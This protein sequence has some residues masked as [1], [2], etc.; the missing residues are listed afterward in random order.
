MK[1]GGRKEGG[2]EGSEGGKKEEKEGGTEG[3][4]EEERERGREGGRKRGMEG[5]MVRKRRSGAAW[6]QPADDG[7]GSAQSV[8]LTALPGTGWLT[9]THTLFL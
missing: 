7:S 9:H 6:R 5:A 1:Q 2:R 4:R 8:S 3:G